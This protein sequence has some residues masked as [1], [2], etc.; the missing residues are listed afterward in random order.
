MKSGKTAKRLLHYI[1]S[2]KGELFPVP[3]GAEGPNATR[4]LTHPHKINGVS[5]NGGIGGENKQ[6]STVRIMDAVPPRG[7]SPAY[8]NGYV[9]Y[10]NARRQKVDPYTGKT[11]S[12]QKGHYEL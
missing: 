12:N 2:P 9:A 3:K 10:E 4:S 11:V 6:V 5:F 8:P 7:K 1:S